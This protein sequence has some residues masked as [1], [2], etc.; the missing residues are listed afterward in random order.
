[1]SGELL[2]DFSRAASQRR[3]VGFVSFY[4]GIRPPI[5][6]CT[7]CGFRSNRGRR[8]TPLR[9]SASR[10]I[11]NYVRRKRR[12]KDGATGEEIRFNHLVKR[13]S[14]S[15]RDSLGRVEALQRET[16]TARK[17]VRFTCNFIFIVVASLIPN[18]AKG[19]TPISV[20]AKNSKG[21]HRAT[22][23]KMATRLS[24][25]TPIK[26]VVR[27]RQRRDPRWWFTPRSGNVESWPSTC[28][29][30][31]RSPIIQSFHCCERSCLYAEFL[32]AVLPSKW[33]TYGHHA[34]GKKPF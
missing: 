11:L 8:R 10:T 21:R 13:A 15:T 24:S 25:Y 33:A 32:R 12:R 18:T 17:I 3:H 2:C 23:K 27:H 16:Q 14:W 4:P 9:W 26:R 6:I 20:A 5:P 34:A 22:R 7:P 1:M 28:H 29:D 19:Y 30:A 31:Q